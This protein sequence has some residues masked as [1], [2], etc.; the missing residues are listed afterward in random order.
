MKWIKTSVLCDIKD[1]NRSVQTA[2]PAFPDHFILSFTFFGELG[3]YPERI[4]VF[5]KLRPVIF[6]FD[7]AS[8]NHKAECRKQHS[9]DDC[10]FI[11]RLSPCKNKFRA[12]HRAVFFAKIR[13]G[14]VI[15]NSAVKQKQINVNA[16]SA[17]TVA[18]TDIMR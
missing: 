10:F 9:A 12:A 8:R 4:S 14:G 5:V 1:H 17:H 2:S 7:G 16:F 18:D 13:V 6:L 11:V 15:L 3:G